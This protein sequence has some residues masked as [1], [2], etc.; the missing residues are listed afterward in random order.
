MVKSTEEMDQESTSTS[1]GI[2]LSLPKSRQESRSRSNSRKLSVTRL[3]SFGNDTNGGSDHQMS[4]VPNFDVVEPSDT[5][6]D[7]SST[8]LSKLKGMFKFASSVSSS[9]INLAITPELEQPNPFNSTS[10]TTKPDSDICTIQ[11]QPNDE[12]SVIAKPTSSPIQSASSSF[13]KRIK[14]RLRSPSMP[15]PNSHSQLNPNFQS[16]RA[17]TD[18][19]VSSNPYFQ[20]QGLP[21]HSNKL[22]PLYGLENG[23][24]SIKLKH[25]QSANN[26]TVSLSKPNSSTPSGRDSHPSISSA[27]NSTS[28]LFAIQKRLRRVASAPL[29]LKAMAQEEYQHSHSQQ[30]NLD[31]NSATF[32]KPKLPI[33]ELDTHIG[34][35]KTRPRNRSVG[36]TYSS[37]ARKICDAQ[38]NEK[39]FEKIKLLGRGDV[40][41]VYLVRE[42][43]THKL[44][45][46]KVLKKKE[47]IRRNKINRALAEQ[48]ILATSNHPFIVTLYHSFQSEEYLYLCTEYCMGGEFFRALKTRKMKCISEDDARFYAAEVTA[49]LEYLHLM[50]FIYRDLKP[51]NI[52]LHQSGHIMLSDFDLSKQISTTKD[53]VIVG[54]RNTPTLDTK[55]CVDGF[56][57]N[58][59]VGTEEYIAPEVIHGNGHTSAV[60][61][62]T[63]G[64]FIY[65]MLVGTTPFKGN[66]RK[67]TFS[68]ILKYEPSFPDNHPVS[69]QCKS[70]I[71]RLLIKD[72][73][74]RLGSKSGASEIKAHPWFKATRW[75]LLR[76]QKPPLIPVFS[77]SSS[78]S[79]E[80]KSELQQDE[81]EDEAGSGAGD[82]KTDPN[83]PDLFEHF[84]SITLHHEYQNGEDGAVMYDVDELGDIS[85]AATESSGSHTS[86]KYGGMSFLK[87]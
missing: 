64:I 13:V 71:K 25:H 57:T 49:A 53:P 62:W 84:N 2:S 40:G 66:T 79:K 60:D 16:K 22:K 36:R 81:E 5:D 14:T 61:W 12:H 32:L 26:S 3:F 18:N 74:L 59:F 56:R 83:A 43:A 7:H 24:L 28:N 37:N 47:M 42:H 52:L 4:P 67:K 68:N 10:L 77:K 78:P 76:N 35:L 30:N 45:A 82:E 85:Y 72:E 17:E 1:K 50:G 38:V 23:D 41:K 31:I 46:M 65:E 33:N 86:S 75:A 73:N 69:H 63:L 44:Y 20:H 80:E 39:S 70:I 11:E 19:V 54:N 29:G 51:E 55:A 6:E 87:R 8:R 48:E 27:R 15:N 21:P 34:E 9:Q 58:S